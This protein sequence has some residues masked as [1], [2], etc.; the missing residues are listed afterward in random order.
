MELKWREEEA[1]LGFVLGLLIVPY[2]IEIYYSPVAGPYWSLLIVPYGIEIRIPHT[3][4]ASRRPF[5][6]TLWNWNTINRKNAR[7][8]R[9]LL[10][11]PYV[12]EIINLIEIM[13]TPTTFNRTLWNW[14]SINPLRLATPHISFNRTLWNWNI[15][16][17][18]ISGNTLNF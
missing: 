12:I 18:E 17:R 5:N 7:W 2:G 9:G 4:A 11:L 6:R 1:Y 13:T 3:Y 15:I 16:E 14:N 10:I 8:S